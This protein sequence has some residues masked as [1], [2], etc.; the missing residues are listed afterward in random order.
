MKNLSDQAKE[1]KLMLSIFGTQAAAARLQNISGINLP[2]NFNSLPE[3]EKERRILG[4]CKIAIEE[5]KPTGT[6]REVYTSLDQIYEDA[7]P[8]QVTGQELLNGRTHI[9]GQWQVINLS[10][11]LREQVI[12]KIAET[13]GGRQATKV[14][15]YNALRYGRPQHWALSRFLLVKYSNPAHFSYCAGQD[16][17]Y[18][19][20]DLRNSLKK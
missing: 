6:P 16:M 4:A 13:A 17:T 11:E 18:E 14:K 5:D 10:D 20:R 15:V 7:Q 19:M 3:E 12:S 8:H 1:V 9:C 2:D